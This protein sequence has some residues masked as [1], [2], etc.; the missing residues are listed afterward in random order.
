[1]KAF[2]D[3][4]ATAIQH[5]QLY[6]QARRD[7]E[8]KA[9]LLNEVNHRVKNN[10]SAI[11]GLLYIELHYA[12][13]QTDLDCA[14]LLTEMVSRIQGLAMVHSALSEAEWAPL[15]LSDLTEHVIRMSLQASPPGRH[16]SL[17]VA[18]SPVRVT[19]DQAHNLALVINELAFN[20][21]KHAWKDRSDGCLGVHITSEGDMIMFEM[22][23]DGV[24]YPAGVLSAGGGMGLYLVRSLVEH[25]LHG[26][27]SVRNERGAVTTVRFRKEV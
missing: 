3:H 21:V 12:R 10:L 6:Q 24:G 26:N 18:P 17:E 16:V 25:G 5:A 23:D 4:A 14:S 15:P 13:W 8:T 11:I 27:V 1:L 19:P 9:V 22:R 2:A 20:T 7:A